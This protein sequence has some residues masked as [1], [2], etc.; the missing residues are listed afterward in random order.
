MALPD[1]SQVFLVVLLDRDEEEG[2]FRSLA[3]YQI[4]GDVLS[5]SNNETTFGTVAEIA[6]NTWL[7]S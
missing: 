1:E 5:C 4:P 3:T 7:S 6:A 2:V